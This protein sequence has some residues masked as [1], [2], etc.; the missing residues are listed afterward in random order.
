LWNGQLA[1]GFDATLVDKIDVGAFSFG[2]VPILGAYDAAGLTNYTR[3]PGS[4]PEFKGL[5]HINYNTGPWNVRYEVCYVKG[6]TDERASPS[7]NDSTGNTIGVKYPSVG[8][9]SLDA[10]GKAMTTVAEHCS[11]GFEVTN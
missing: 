7:V 11:D 3:F 4:V 9:Q 5:G 1:L 8:I 2:G 10:P 6:V